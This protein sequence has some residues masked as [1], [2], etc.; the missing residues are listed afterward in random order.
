[1]PRNVTVTFADGTQKIYQNVPDTATPGTVVA[2]AAKDFPGQNIRTI[3]GGKGGA[4]VQTRQQ[5]VQQAARQAVAAKQP[6]FFSSVGSGIKDMAEGAVAGVNSATYGLPNHLASALTQF[7]PGHASTYSGEVANNQAMLNQAAS[8]APVTNILANLGESYATGKGE[9][10][11]GKALV[12]RL[13]SSGIGA[14]AKVGNALNKVVPLAQGSKIAPLTKGQHLANAARIIATGAGTGA[15]QAAGT[16]DDVGTGAALG[17]AGAAGALGVGLLGRAAM[18]PVSDLLG[19]TNAAQYLR[20]FTS[21]SMDAI[22]NKAA[23]FR[24]RTGAEPTLFELLPLADRNS[25]IARGIAGR[26]SVVEQATDLAKQ[27]AAN[28]GPEMQNV[29]QSATAPQRNM[30]AAQIA[31][32]L[33]TARGGVSDPADAA[34]AARAVRSPTDMQTVRRTEASAIMAPHDQA[35]VVNNFDDLHPQTQELHQPPTTQTPVTNPQGQPLL[36][37]QGQ[38]IMRSVTPPPIVRSTL[39][40]PEASAAIRS[41]AGRSRVRPDDQGYT[42][43]DVTNMISDLRED[44]GQGGIDGRAAGRAADHLLGLMG[45]NVPDAADATN[46][47]RNAF[48]SRSRM[49]EGM[50]EGNAGRLRDDIQVGTNTGKAQLVR[51]AYDSEE[52]VAGRQVGQA[53]AL[54]SDLSGTPGQALGTTVDIARGGAPAL[55]E[56]LG[57]NAGGQIRSAAQAQDQSAQAL[58][59]MSNRVSGTGEE[60]ASAASLGHALVALSPHTFTTTKLNALQHIKNMSFM[61]ENRAR[62]L[63]DML[64]SQDPTMTDRAIGALNGSDQGKTFLQTLAPAVMGSSALTTAGGTS[65]GLT[66]AQLPPGDPNAPQPAPQEAPPAVD[67]AADPNAQ[68]ASPAAAP[69]PGGMPDPN[70]YTPLT[71]AAPVDP[72][73]SQYMPALQHIYDND[74]PNF[75]NFVESHQKQESGGKQ[76]DKNGQ[77][78]TSKAGAVGIM[79]IEPDTAKVIAKRAGIP[80]DPIA[81]QYDP[82]YNKL[83]GT[84]H[85]AHLLQ[86]YN[87]DTQKASAAYNAGE[88]AVDRATDQN[89]NLVMGNLPAETQGYVPAVA[90]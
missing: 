12:G 63:V 31:N 48:A 2:R 76:Y 55:E 73:Q 85:V 6:G 80:Y 7:L 75:L 40:D 15:A 86:K 64:F 47:M 24:A 14:V 83:L 79:Q 10:A 27:R 50:Q 77:P 90:G 43:Q 22:Q 16:G 71:N 54:S 38:P 60:P 3:D 58:A 74:D 25:L 69:L 41:V 57:A 4:N 65:S 45:T 84:M 21:A 88:G 42:V 61:P 19:Q 33:A 11:A 46:A 29:V 87:G 32:D 44:A 82:A 20:R 26:D 23:D 13:A 35:T 81:L 78:L 28:I 70:G 66:P 52:G 59:S 18:R 36:D 17:T 5:G 37:V 62:T 51:N 34:L 89:G 1:M 67:P 39:T 8:K 56:N 9:V 49:I 72:S 53:N 30:T 68:P